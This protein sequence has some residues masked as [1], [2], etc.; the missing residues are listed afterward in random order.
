[1]RYRISNRIKLLICFIVLVVSRYLAFDYEPK[2]FLLYAGFYLLYALDVGFFMNDIAYCV[3]CVALAAGL[4]VVFG[5]DMV[6][7]FLPL[8]VFL[9]VFSW[10][11]EQNNPKAMAASR[12]IPLVYMDLIEPIVL[13][14]YLAKSLKNGLL[15]Q[16]FQQLSLFTGCFIFITIALLYYCRVTKASGNEKSTEKSADKAFQY[17]FL[18]ITYIE[19][20][21]LSLL[22]QQT[23]YYIIVLTDLWISVV[24]FIYIRE[25]ETE[26]VKGKALKAR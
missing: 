14:F 26:T 7:L 5:V 21:V 10:R 20:I 19:S 4:W 17:G 25:K 6:L 1:M 23:Y 18:L 22:Q 13:F 9:A 16:S 24:L 2:E 3:G 15:L 12:T 8:L 11:K